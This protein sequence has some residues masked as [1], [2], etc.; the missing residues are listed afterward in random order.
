MRASW[1]GEYLILGLLCKQPRHG[2][3]LAQLAG[4]DEA[5]RT[6]WCLKRS[7]VYFLLD[8]LLAGALI[9]ERSDLALAAG[10]APGAPGGPPRVVFALTPGGRKVFERWL[11]TPEKSPVICVQPS[12]PCCIWRAGVTLRLRPAFCC[13]T[14][15]PGRVARPLARARLREFICENGALAAP[16]PGA[17]WAGSTR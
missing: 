4:N 13:P 8:K 15:N 9:E 2:Y 5:L 14:Q 17:G 7:E 10:P 6:V 1:P 12:W 16:W 11:V 3:E